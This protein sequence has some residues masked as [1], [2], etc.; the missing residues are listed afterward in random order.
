[1]TVKFK[2]YYEVLGV[3]RTA[4]AEEIQRAFRSMARKAH[5]DV[6]K[7]AGAEE[8]FKELNEAY[9][10]LK[11]PEKRKRYDQLG[12][13][14][15]D[16]QDF[17][18]PPGWQQGAPFDFEVHTGG[19]EEGDLGGFSDFFSSLFGG[20]RFRSAAR[21]RGPRRG[22]DHEVQIELTL[23]EIARGGVK[24]IQIATQ[25]LDES[26]RPATETKTYDVTL[27]RGITA[28]SRI[29][30]GGQGGSGSDGG[31]A[32]DLHLVVAIRAHPRF[33][34]QGHDLRTVCS[35]T[36]WEA[37]LGAQIDLLTLTGNV[38]LKVASGTQN[39][40]VLRLRGQGLPIDADRSGDLL[41]ELRIVVPD[42]PTGEERE[43]FEKLARASSF[44]PAERTK[45]P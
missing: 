26:G 36:P 43:L 24:P 44:A 40:Q 31:G 30:L 25:R 16:G 2:D 15:K 21:P 20:G 32:G 11:D 38:T 42:K 9:E 19:F 23:E 1:M 28:G 45:R 4:T 5:P 37:V 10:V 22:R 35:V 33:A 12:A 14:W 8:R 13:S 17:E 29:R 7:T 6:D 39:G 34:V 41:V 18:P 27:P 3:E